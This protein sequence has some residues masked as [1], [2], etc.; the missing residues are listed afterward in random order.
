MIPQLLSQFGNLVVVSVLC[1]ALALWIAVRVSWR[2]CL[3][4]IFAVFG[5]AGTLGVI[6]IIFSGCLMAPWNVH[7]P[8]GHAGYSTIAYGGLA[9]V[10]TAGQHQIHRRLLASLA[11]AIWIFLIGL[12][13]VWV[14]AHTMEEVIAGWTIGGLG[15]ILFSA[16]YH[17]PRSPSM[18]FELPALGLVLFIGLNPGLHFTPEPNL[19]G[20]GWWLA[21]NTSMCQMIRATTHY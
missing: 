7:S 13:R 21:N 3:L 9:I 16:F 8:S 6:K 12:S 18:R 10:A 17:A 4:W 1:A 19:Q 11:A 2:Y 14:H 5:V 20:L 15:L